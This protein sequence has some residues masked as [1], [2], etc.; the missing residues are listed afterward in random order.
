[1]ASRAI[2][3]VPSLLAA[4]LA[5]AGDEVNRVYAAGADF[6]HVD[7]L[8]GHF[9]PNLSFGPCVVAAIHKACAIPM[10]V[11]LMVTDP[12]LFI[13]PYAEAGAHD[14]L[15]HAELD[16]DG[17]ALARKIRELGVRPGVVLEMKT[18]P[19]HVA[20]L[21]GEVDVLMVMTI[22]D[23][24][25]TGQAFRPEPASKIPV[26]RELFGEAVDIAVDGGVSADNIGLLAKA[27]ADFFVAGKAIFWAD[28][29]AQAIQSLRS[30]AEA[31]SK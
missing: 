1:M 3:I 30:A 29:P 27:G 7:V 2:K 25:F 22:Q 18:P 10:S 31:A 15:F 4:D 12:E 9:A 16:L 26:L 28:D 23:C 13:Q 11:H 20:G 8:D 21:V 6:L 24:G 17:V 5:R 14:L 19:E